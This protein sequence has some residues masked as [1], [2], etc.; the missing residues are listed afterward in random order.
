MKYL[1]L[2][3]FIT[4][5]VII[6]KKRE[7]LISILTAAKNCK[8]ITEIANRLYVS[9]PYI[10]KLVKEY[11]NKYNVKLIDRKTT[12]IKLTTAGEILL[13]HLTT[14]VNDESKLQ[15]DMRLISKKELGKISITFNQPFAT[16]LGGK[17]FKLLDTK[18]PNVFF[19]FYEDTTYLAQQKLLNGQTDIFVGR[20]LS[21]QQ[22]DV[23]EITTAEKPYFLIPKSNDLYYKIDNHED[24]YENLS[25]FENQEF[26]G[27]NGQSQFQD[28]IDNMFKAKNVNIN[29]KANMPNTVAAT[30][31]A[32]NSS[33]IAITL[34][35]VFSNMKLPTSKFKLIPVPESLFPSYLGVS[36]IK[37]S[38]VLIKKIA[39]TL[40]KAAFDHYTDVEG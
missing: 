5:E 33:S 34:P 4:K 32:I 31:A 38:N 10:T 24:L 12:P 2:L 8:T 11:E 21:N 16:V 17:L 14:I 22:I 27:I 36:I 19:D 18:F 25:I 37:N 13:Q 39:K 28:L 9:Q 40:A 35:L 3:F 23:F 20:A 6:L 30:F 29:L 26:I 15:Q 7:T 1:F